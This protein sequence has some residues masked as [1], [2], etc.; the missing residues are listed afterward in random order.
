MGSV[1][2]AVFPVAGFGTRFLPATKAM[3]KALLPIIDRPLIQFAVDEALAAGVESLV[4]ITGRGHG[5]IEDYFDM[6]YE[7]ERELVERG[8]AHEVDELID[9]RPDAGQ[10]VFV[11]QVEPLGLGHAVWCARNVVGQGPFAV[12]LADELIR[13]EPGA[14]KRMIDV[15]DSHGGN[16]VLVDEVDPASVGSY[17]IVT[18]LEDHGDHVTVA[19][20]VE[21]PTPEDAPSNLAV[22]GRYV[23]QS[24]VMDRL[25][26]TTP[27]AGGEIQLTDAILASLES[28]ELRALRNTGTRFDCG[29][30]QGFLEATIEL[31]RQRP[32]LAGALE[33]I[34]NTSPSKN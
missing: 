10:I 14:L 34:T 11:R 2:T 9:L 8:R 5:A 4:F 33:G 15:H 16:V 31:A 19:S 32:D 21:K 13:D 18:P 29:S 12:L 27:G 1:K 20:V 24:D 25:S 3:P 6:S 17:G 30:P 28:T 26:S 7:L 22:I 23:L